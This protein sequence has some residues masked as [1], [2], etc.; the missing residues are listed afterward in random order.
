MSWIEVNSGTGGGGAI[1][2]KAVDDYET[3]LPN[4]GDYEGTTAVLT[5]SSVSND[6]TSHVG[7][8]VNFVD[9]TSGEG[10]WELLDASDFVTGNA[11]NLVGVVTSD[12]TASTP[13][14]LITVS[15]THLTLP[16]NREV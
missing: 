6:L 15:Y 14:V 3:D 5:R 10:K 12:T 7:K 1:N 16:T 13:S 11:Y 9:T 4:L 8:F 2:L